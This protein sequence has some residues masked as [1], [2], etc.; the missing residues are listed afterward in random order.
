MANP[1]KLIITSPST[2]LPNKMVSKS[3]GSVIIKDS[4]LPATAECASFKSKSHPNPSPAAALKSP[5]LWKLTQILKL[6]DWLEA[7]SCNSSSSIILLI[8]Q[9]A[10][11]VVNATFKTTPCSTATAQVDTTNSKEPSK[12]RTLVLWSSLTWTDAFTAPDVSD[13]LKKSAAFMIWVHQEEEEELKLTPTL[14]K[15]C[16]RKWAVT[17]LMSAQSVP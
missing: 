17:W 3:P 1:I 6:P 2:K 10:I 8:A 5:L 15:C 13:L 16:I 7:V 11:K 9:F 12:T 14:K 4:K